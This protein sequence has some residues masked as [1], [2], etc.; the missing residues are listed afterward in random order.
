MTRLIGLPPLDCPAPRVL[1]LGSFP[2]VRSLELGQ[3]YGHERNHFWQIMGLVFETRVPEAYEEKRGLLATRKVAVWDAIAACER[4]G[5]LDQDIEYETPNRILEFLAARPSISRV[6]LNGGKA[7]TSFAS[8]F[9]LRAAEFA[10][11]GRTVEWRPA[12]L[13]DRTLLAARLPS[14]SPIPTRDFRSAADKAPAW[15]AFLR[16]GGEEGAVPGAGRRPREAPG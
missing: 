2:S 15:A 5:S 6:A 1:V 8:H 14:S 11:I 13:A 4:E 7:S 16:G 3:Y 12:A 9:G 10:L